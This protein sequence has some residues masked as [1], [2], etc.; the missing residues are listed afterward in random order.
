MDALIRQ[1]L[2][3][4][5]LGGIYALVALAV[6]MVYQATRHV[7][8]AIGETAMF[9]ASVAAACFQAAAPYWVGL[10]AAVATAFVLGVAIERLL[11]ERL[12][13]ASA[14]S[15]VVVMIGLLLVFNSVAGWLF[16]FTVRPFPSPFP[17]ART[18]YLSPHEIGVIAVSLIVVVALYG[19]LQH[20][21][22]GLAMR[23][24]AD[25]RT[26]SRLVGIR[27]GWMLALGWGVASAIAAV[28][29]ML[30]APIVY[31]EPNMMSPVLIYGFAA[32]LLGGIDSPA[33]AV[34]GGFLVGMFENVA[35]AYLVGPELKLVAALAVIVAVLMVRPAGLF[36][37]RP[38]ARV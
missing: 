5:A 28:A 21:R 24:T 8:F 23:A 37:T 27:A 16:G 32:A 22:L 3:G 33:G 35:G 19:F 17:P 26:S 25:N 9:S 29:A 14:L 36:G 12:E 31:L 2:S 1:V 10:L 7:N 11:V 6:V 18:R 4:A 30:V 34:V 38:V 15:V 20:T 13:R